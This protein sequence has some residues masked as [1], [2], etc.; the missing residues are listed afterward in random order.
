MLRA[1]RLPEILAAYSAGG[2]HSADLPGFVL[3][4]G[5]AFA[6]APLTEDERA[7][8]A[9]AIGHKTFQ[10][11]LCF[12]NAQRMLIGDITGRL[13]YAEGYVFSDG[14]GPT[15]HAWVGIGGK[16]VDPTLTLTD[17]EAEYYGVRIRRPYVLAMVDER[18]CAGSLLD[19]WEYERPIVQQGVQ[20]WR[21]V[22]DAS[23]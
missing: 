9:A 22:E 2:F 21:Y 11:Q 17:P 6:S 8:V 1:R 4:E 14:I 3:R 12:E 16:A 10:A 20:G 13:V 19:D 5:L 23:T 15:L 18:G 7:I